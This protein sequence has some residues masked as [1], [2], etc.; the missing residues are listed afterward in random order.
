MISSDSGVPPTLVVT[1]SELK[2][3]VV[4]NPVSAHAEN[5][6]KLLRAGVVTKIAEV[7]FSAPS[8][9][10]LSGLEYLQRRYRIEKVLMPGNKRRN[11]QFF[12]RITE[13][14]GEFYFV[15]EGSGGEKLKL[16]REKNKFAIEYPDSGVML[17]WRLEINDKDNGR[18]ITFIRKG[19]KVS[20]TLPWSSKNGVWQHEL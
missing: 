12:D 4:I 1:D 8:V 13:G 14:G 15:P 18:E 5:M 6:G 7:G 20:S 2:E 17:G 11:W 19:K 9:R 3:A 10:N 16:F